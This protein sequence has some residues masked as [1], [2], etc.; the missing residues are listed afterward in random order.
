MKEMNL[1][2]LLPEMLNTIYDFLNI[3]DL[4]RLNL[5]SKFWKEFN[6]KK[7]INLPPQLKFVYQALN[8]KEKYILINRAYHLLSLKDPEKRF[9]Y[10]L[11][12]DC[13]T[14]R[15]FLTPITVNYYYSAPPLALKHLCLL[16]KI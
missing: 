12:H 1:Q 14:L 2:D 15:D 9:E 3:V 5:V 8:T 7:E 13:L 4:A 16:K 10:F 6:S 11:E